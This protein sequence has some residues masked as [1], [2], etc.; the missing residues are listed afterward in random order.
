MALTYLT[1]GL[2][3]DFTAA[4]VQSPEDQ[5]AYATR[6]SE[7]ENALLCQAFGGQVPQPGSQQRLQRYLNGEISRAE[8]FQPLYSVG[9]HRTN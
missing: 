4:T 7:V 6:L 3:F 8:A 5:L 1:S 9:Q 2:Q